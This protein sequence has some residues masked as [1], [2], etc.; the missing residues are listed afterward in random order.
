MDHHFDVVHL[1]PD[2]E[3]QIHHVIFFSKHGCSE[4]V[5][6][7]IYYS[8]AHSFGMVSAQSFSE[9]TAFY[10][11]F[12]RLQNFMGQEFAISLPHEY[13]SDR[14]DIS[15]EDMKRLA[16]MFIDGLIE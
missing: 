4:N 6:C 2:D 15:D 10:I 5:A 13:L 3:C 9:T 16:S 7:H 14:E 12:A 8:T 1:A 11:A